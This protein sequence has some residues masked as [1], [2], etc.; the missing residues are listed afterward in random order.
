MST[1]ERTLYTEL[2]KAREEM[3][4]LTKDAKNPHFKSNYATL[5]QVHNIAVPALHKHD[6]LVLEGSDMTA[7]GPVQWL[8]LHHVESGDEII[9]SLPLVC[10]D[11]SNPQHLGSAQTYARRYL[12]QAVAGLTPEDDDG[13][14]ASGNRLT[15]DKE[16]KQ[17]LWERMISK[18]ETDGII[19]F[20]DAQK[21]AKAEKCIGDRGW[22]AKSFT[23]H[24]TKLY[25][26]AQAE[27]GKE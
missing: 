10:K 23:D 12:L 21:R 8:K 4:K 3:G 15:G 6:I 9:S 1:E 13:N 19:E 27:K 17:R 20:F 2:Y 7:N 22:T 11:P 25:K 16:E 5:E 24:L 14:S 18:M 26:E